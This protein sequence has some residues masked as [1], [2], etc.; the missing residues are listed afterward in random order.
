MRIRMYLMGN[1]DLTGYLGKSLSMMITFE[2]IQQ[3]GEHSGYSLIKAINKTSDRLNLKAGTIY[4]QLE[5]YYNDEYISRRTEIITSK[6][7]AREREV[8]IFSLTDLGFAKLNQMRSEW[9]ELQ[10]ILNE[11]IPRRIKD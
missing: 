6:S 9:M 1:S 3:D 2:L 8:A 11:N 7:T 5:K 10:I 4:S